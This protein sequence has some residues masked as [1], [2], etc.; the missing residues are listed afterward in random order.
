LLLLSQH[1]FQN[2]PRSQEGQAKLEL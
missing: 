1:V 2:V